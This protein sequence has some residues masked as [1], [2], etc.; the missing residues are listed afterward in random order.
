MVPLV[1]LVANAIGTQWYYSRS[2]RDC[3]A[4]LVGGLPV[5]VSLFGAIQVFDALVLVAA[6]ATSSDAVRWWARAISGITDAPSAEVKAVF[7]VPAVRDALVRVAPH[8]TTVDS[9]ICLEM[10]VSLVLEPVQT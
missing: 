6:H 8:A 3:F 7:G 4:A 1:P 10:A 2:H 5:V 9:R